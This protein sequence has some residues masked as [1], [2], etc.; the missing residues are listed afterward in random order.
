MNSPY[1]TNANS[2]LTQSCMAWCIRNSNTLTIKAH[3]FHSLK[4]SNSNSTSFVNVWNWI[5]LL[6]ILEVDYFR[7][8]W[9]RNKTLMLGFLCFEGNFHFLVDAWSIL[10][11]L[12]RLLS[13]LGTI[14]VIWPQYTHKL[15][16]IIFLIKPDCFYLE[17]ES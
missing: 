5:N 14:L 17:F 9:K 15:G 4:N 16:W 13:E 3:R 12:S 6:H 7:F 1:Q 11:A 2:S 10:L 8:F